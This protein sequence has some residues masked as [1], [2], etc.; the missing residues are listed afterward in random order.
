MTNYIQIDRT[1][2]NHYFTRVIES[3]GQAVAAAGLDAQLEVR[4]LA[5]LEEVTA[6]GCGGVC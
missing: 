1:K 6:S 5:L 3:V 4:S 2:G